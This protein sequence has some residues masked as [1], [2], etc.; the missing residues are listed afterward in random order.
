MDETTIRERA[1]GEKEL[2][3]EYGDEHGSK[4]RVAKNYPQIDWAEW[5][6]DRES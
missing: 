2:R 6:A 1:A 3:T 5:S 4:R